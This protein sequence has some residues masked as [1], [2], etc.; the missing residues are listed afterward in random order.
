MSIGRKA[1]EE[2][3]K[4]KNEE[5]NVQTAELRS[6]RLPISPTQGKDPLKNEEEVQILALN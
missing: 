5:N 3:F 6:S 4:K 2:F 1:V